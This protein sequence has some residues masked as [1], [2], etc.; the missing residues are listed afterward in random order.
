MDLSELGQLKQKKKFLKEANDET[1]ELL[2]KDHNEKLLE[3][4]NK[5]LSQTLLNHTADLLCHLKVVQEKYKSD[6]N[7]DLQSNSLLKK[8]LERIV[9]LVTPYITLPFVG[10]VTGGM[11]IGKYAI[12]SR[13]D[14]EEEE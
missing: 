7:G 12:K 13:I 6:L 14:G 2:W 3:E 9:G 5:E 4:K 11:T 10:G 8:D 1:I